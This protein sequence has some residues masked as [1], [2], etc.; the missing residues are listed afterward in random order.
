MVAPTR[1][2]ISL[3][4]ILSSVAVA[5]S[6]ALL[7]GWTL[8]IV[9]HMSEVKTTFGGNVW[10]L[11]GGIVSFIAIITVLVMF[12]V[13]LV[14]E[15]REVRRQTSFIDSVTHELKTPLASLRLAAETMARPE[16]APERREQLR[17]MMLDDVSRLVALVD[18]ILEASRILG[19]REV[20][21]RGEVELL[22]MAEQVVH[23]MITRHRIDREC[24]RLELDAQVVLSV[25]P[26]GLRMVLSNLIDNAIKYSQGR[27]EVVIR[28]EP[29]GSHY[30]ID[31]R[32]RGIGIDRRDLK[33]IFQRFYRVPVEAVRS[34][35][36][37]G[38]GLFVVEALVQG[39]GGKIEALSEGTGQGTT[40]RVRLPMERTSEH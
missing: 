25:D 40:M 36:G 5:L 6:L 2:S 37:T 27:P 38:L 17:M 11:V 39:M 4:I 22:P 35:H 23:D 13:F 10:L 26:S 20:R 34:R 29:A 16:L 3:P 7:V 33:R 9:Q 31:V 32:D 21:E 28:G 18:G 1:R 19:G 8:V 24:V 30:V 14:R 15:I 12:T